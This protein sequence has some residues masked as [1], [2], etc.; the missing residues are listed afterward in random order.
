MDMSNEFSVIHCENKYSSKTKFSTHSTLENVGKTG[1][2][3]SKGKCEGNI[4]SLWDVCR[5]ESIYSDIVVF[6]CLGKLLLDFVLPKKSV[7][8]LLINKI[9]N[10]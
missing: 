3:L 6:I 10:L 1:K 8:K 9:R 2:C 5:R 4:S 7:Y